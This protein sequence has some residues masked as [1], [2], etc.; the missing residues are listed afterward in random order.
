MKNLDMMAKIPKYK[1]SFTAKSLEIAETKKATKRVINTENKQ[2]AY[3][4]I[5]R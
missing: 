1:S 5:D 3:Q 4:G 2:I